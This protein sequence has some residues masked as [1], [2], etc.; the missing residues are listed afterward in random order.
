MNGV[1]DMGGMQDMGPVVTDRDEPVF[2]EPWEGRLFAMRRA[3][4]AWGKWNIDASRHGVELVPPEDYL[5]LG[6]YARQFVALLPMIVKSGLV[7][8][9]EID[10][11]TPAAGQPKTTPAL[12]PEKAQVLIARGIPASRDVK[13]AARFN[14]GER[15]RTRNLNPVG[16]TRLPRYARGKI[17]TISIDHGVFVLPD[18]NAHFKGENPQH[19]YSVRF[20]ARE[21]WGNAVSEKD[22]V[23][24]DMWDDYLD[25]A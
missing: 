21:L 16:H 4:A 19:L 3:M 2:H 1:H 23:N 20:S 22:S 5:R 11:G 9:A 17:G 24:L 25:P 10:S 8:Q 12:T 14:V 7:S 18:T 6:Y 13:L 15:V